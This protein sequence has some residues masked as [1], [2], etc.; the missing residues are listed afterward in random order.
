ATLELDRPAWEPD[1]TFDVRRHVH[2]VALPA[3]GGDT[4]LRELLD[5]LLMAPLDA[6]HPLW[7]VH[8]I[9]GLA[10]GSSVLFCKMHHCMIDGVSG[11]QILEH[12]TDPAPETVPSSEPSCPLSA[13]DALDLRP[14][15][16]SEGLS[17][18]LRIPTPAAALDGAR[19]AGEALTTIAGLLREPS[20]RLPFNQPLSDRRTFAWATLSL[21]DVLAVRGRAGC[22]ANDVLLAVIAGALHRHLEARGVE[23][24]QLRVRTIVP[25]SVRRSH[26]RLQLG[27][28]VSAMLPR[29]PV[30][31]PDPAARLRAVAQETQELKS[32]GQPRAARL[33]LQLLDALPAPVEALL[34][35][36]A[37]EGLLANTICTNVPG[38]REVRYLLGHRVR[39]LH[40][41]VPLMQS[42]GVEFAIL[43]YAGTVSIT[44]T[45]DPSLVPDVRE[46]AGAL[47]ESARELVAAYRVEAE[48]VQR[49]VRSPSP[50]V[51]DLMT[52]KVISIRPADSLLLAFRLMRTRRIRHLPVLD[53]SSRLIGIVTH[54]D[55]L[56]AASS[57]LDR[58][59]VDAQVHVLA[60]SEA[61]EVME[62]H[63][64]VASPH[65]PAAAAGA[66]MIGHKIGCLPVLDEAGR[67]V[68]IVTEE[69]FVRWATE[70]M[71]SVAATPTS[72]RA[73]ARQS[74][75]PA[76]RPAD[77][78]V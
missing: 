35:R 68:G 14:A 17:A 42:M 9:D 60:G 18:W 3:P 71:A 20:D 27:N 47:E 30:G 76:A 49:P 41:L 69:D 5:C 53:A 44:V 57:S 66:R 56:A 77:A 10:T 58:E 21:D 13:N 39:A 15:E 2:H 25:V 26:E 29:L 22:K 19:M 72:A 48:E 65:E 38:P 52:R 59:T 54:R 51:A 34:G 7:E 75:S 1:P 43:S 16:G 63:L 70:N 6:R 50:C 78:A 46:L 40:G 28:L 8:L 32:R 24:G 45:A 11:A 36:L 4:E 33:M 67:L 61:S 12:L 73:P 37:P 23:T 62:T 74:P 55:L 31:I 64:C